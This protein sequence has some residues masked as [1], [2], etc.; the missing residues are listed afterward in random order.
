VAVAGDGSGAPVVRGALA[1]ATNADISVAAAQVADRVQAMA[2]DSVGN[3]V[4]LLGNAEVRKLGADLG[5]IWAVVPNKLISIAGIAA[6]P[7]GDIFFTGATSEALPGKTHNGAS[8]IVVGKITGGGQT[9]WMDEY[10]SSTS[11]NGKSIWVAPDG[12]A[13]V[14]GAARQLPGQPPPPLGPWAQFAMKYRADGS[15]VWVT[16]AADVPASA[17]SADSAANVYGTLATG[18]LAFTKVAGDGSIA[19]KKR[20]NI[21]AIPGRSSGLPGLPEVVSSAPA[22][23]GDGMYWVG[24]DRARASTS[25]Y[26]CGLGHMNSDGSTWFRRGEGEKAIVEPVEQVTWNGDIFMCS[27][28]LATSNAVYVTGIYGNHYTHGSVARPSSN[29]SFVARYDLEGNRVWFR[30]VLITERLLDK[31][32]PKFLAQGPQNTLV[33]ATQDGFVFGVQMADGAPLPR[34][35]PKAP[36]AAAAAAAAATPTAAAPAK[37]EPAAKTTPAAKEQV[38]ADAPLA[39]EG[40][41]AA[42]APKRRIKKKK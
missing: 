20:P 37:V 33:A 17:L 11:D 9:A 6:T 42:T 39:N 15:R 14:L 16:Q 24:G 32:E 19:W 5:K 7:N 25:E 27:G 40:S 13:I 1:G 21:G 36:A 30:Q 3:I 41:A 23:N 34:F 12:S 2:V 31:H 10:G 26:G 4:L 18:G 8:D 22:P 38:V 29:P 35:V 28:I